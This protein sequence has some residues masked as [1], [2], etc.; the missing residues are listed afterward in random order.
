LAA[1][2][3]DFSARKSTKQAILFYLAFVFLSALI[4]HVFGRVFFPPPA[5][6]SGDPGQALGNLFAASF[7]SDRKVAP[8]INIPLSVVLAMLSLQAKNM[9]TGRGMGLLALNIAL[10]VF[11]GSLGGMAVPAYLTT[12]PKRN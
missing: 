12:Q 7:E 11:V 6:I 1:G 9:F 4:V 10:A 2:F 8:F 5:D 3:L